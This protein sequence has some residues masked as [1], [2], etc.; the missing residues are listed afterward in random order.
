MVGIICAVLTK[1]LGLHVLLGAFVAG[2]VAGLL[3]NRVTTL[4]T[5][6]NL[7]AVRLF[8]SFFVP[9]YFFHEGLNVPTGAL[10]FKALIYGA[11]FSILV[12]PLRI[13]K[14]WLVCR[15]TCRRPSSS[16]LRV[17]VALTPTLIFTLVIARI[18]EETFDIDEA[19]YGGLLVYAAT[20]TILPSF[21]LPL[22][23]Q[24]ERSA[25]SLQPLTVGPTDSLANQ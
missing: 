20:S 12:L 11:G 16:G 25:T 22:L 24:Q 5:P 6:E 2:M 4:A 19:L 10:V 23:T 15:Y 9:F 13:A 1:G 7:H 17:G 8:A 3:R 21:V 18:L 14:D